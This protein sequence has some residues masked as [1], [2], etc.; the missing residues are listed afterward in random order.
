[1]IFSNKAYD[2][3][4]QVAV[5]VLPAMGTLYFALCQIWGLPYGEEI[6]G[7]I[8]AVDTFI[9][10][11]IGVSTK[12]Y[13]QSGADAELHGGENDALLEEEHELVEPDD[14]LVN[15]DLGW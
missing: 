15:E 3:L 11:L 6:V 5:I 14:A 8:A 7:T 9:G 1:M 10:A 12:S 4:K 13:N 2:I